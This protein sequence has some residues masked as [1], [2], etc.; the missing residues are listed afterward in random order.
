MSELLNNAALTCLISSHVVGLTSHASFFIQL[1]MF[2]KR[3]TSGDSGDI[4]SCVYH[5]F[6]T[7]PTTPWLCGKEHCFTG[8]QIGVPGPLAFPL[9]TPA[10]F[11]P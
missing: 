7:M 4:A 3:C 5:C 9:L 2:S 6:R 10:N 8:T 1:Q 11:H